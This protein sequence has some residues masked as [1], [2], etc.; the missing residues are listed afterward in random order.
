[1]AEDGFDTLEAVERW[2]LDVFA[3]AA[4]D[5]RSPYRWP[6]LATAGASGPDGRILVLR[7]FDR[8]TRCFSLWSDRRSG[9]FDDLARDARGALLFFDKGRMT[10][11]RV[12]GPVRVLTEG[13]DWEAA[14]AR[15][16]TG[17]LDDYE[18]PLAPGAPLATPAA[19]DDAAEPRDNFALLEL[20]GETVDWLKLSRDGH[21]RATLD[22]SEGGAGHQWRVP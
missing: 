16:S 13:A 20:R 22:W 10:Q 17:P 6:F 21:A 19:N 12:R 11:I 15:A 3:R 18:S 5:N 1:M 8:P 4:V 2:C 9:K 14:F 7:G